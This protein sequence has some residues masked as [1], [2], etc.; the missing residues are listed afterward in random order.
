MSTE[1]NSYADKAGIKAGDRIVAFNGNALADVLDY[2]FWLSEE[3]LRVEYLGADGR[4]HF[5]DIEK[6]QYEDIGLEFK[7]YLIDKKRSCCNRCIFCFV[8]QN[9]PGMRESIYFKDDDERLSFLQG[10][11]ITLTNLTRREVDRIK[12]MHISPINVSVHTTDP[13]LRVKMMGNKNAGKVLELLREICVAGIT[14]NAQIVLCRNWNDGDELLRTLTDL[15]GL[16]PAVESVAVVPS[17]LTKHRNSLAVLTPFDKASSLETLALINSFAEKHLAATGHRFV[18]ASDEFFLT[19]G[20]PLPDPAS[21]ENFMQLDNGVGMLTLHSQEFSRAL[22]RK[23]KCTPR[24]V[25]IAT[26]SAAYAHISELCKAA[27]DK[28]PALDIKVYCIKN[29]FYG[30][31]I[32]VSGLL[33]GQDIAHRLAGKPLGSEL[34]FPACALRAGGDLFLDG[35]TPQRLSQEL[36]V[37]VRPVGN[38]GKELLDALMGK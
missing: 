17:G 2:Q 11:Y 7:T 37:S 34:L 21:Y 29:E 33:T 3:H 4:T 9:P 10:N 5:A 15:A 38:N 14:V 20:V 13:E 6:E 24:S 19:A 23:R 12:Q 36:K 22:R 28:F 18:F 25:S 30:E 26:G 31:S 32:T 1:K 16:F 27:S 35:Y 8:D